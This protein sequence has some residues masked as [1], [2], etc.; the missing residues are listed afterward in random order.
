MTECAQVRKISRIR[1]E[2]NGFASVAEERHVRQASIEEGGVY[3]RNALACGESLH[4]CCEA[5]QLALLA[6]WRRPLGWHPEHVPFQFIP[7]IFEGDLTM[8]PGWDYCRYPSERSAFSVL[9][10]ILFTFA[11]NA[12]IR[13]TQLCKAAFSC[14]DSASSEL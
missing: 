3:V 9:R 1:L 7:D 4:W 6:I 14:R 11:L 2:S 10:S 13:K 5:C 12:G 8:Q